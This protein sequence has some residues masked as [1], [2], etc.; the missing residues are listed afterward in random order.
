MDTKTWKIYR[1][2][3]KTLPIHG[4]QSGPGEAEKG[5]AEELYDKV[6]R[7]VHKE[8]GSYEIVTEHVEELGTRIKKLDWNPDDEESWSLVAKGLKDID[9]RV[10]KERL[11]DSEKRLNMTKGLQL[12]DDLWEHVSTFMPK[13]AS[14]KKRKRTKKKKVS[15]K[16]G[17]VIGYHKKSIKVK[18]ADDTVKNISLGI[19]PPY[20]EV[21][22]IGTK[23]PIVNDGVDGSHKPKI[24]KKYP[25]KSAREIQ[26]ILRT[27][28]RKASKKRSRKSR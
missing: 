4:S 1:K 23:L 24:L 19:W 3:L 11:E 13:R 18:F 25:N 8:D 5:A 17:T 26:D 27:A 14:T 6:L 22:P 21:Y 2:F 7:V 28:S 20:E 9:E 15:R 10:H 12:P 16:I